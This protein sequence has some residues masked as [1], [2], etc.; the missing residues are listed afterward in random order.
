MTRMPAAVEMNSAGIWL[1]SPSPMVSLEKVSAAF[2]S[3]MPCIEAIAMPPIRFR[4]VMI[5]P[6]IA[7]PRTNFEAPSMAP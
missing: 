5:R 3:G 7:S 6:A 4:A 1:T 2:E